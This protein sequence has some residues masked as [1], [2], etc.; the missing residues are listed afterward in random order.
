MYSTGLLKFSCVIM[1]F[2]EWSNGLKRMVLYFMTNVP[3][4]QKVDKFVKQWCS[5]KQRIS[6]LVWFLW[7]TF[8][9]GYPYQLSNTLYLF[10]SCV[11]VTIIIH[12]PCVFQNSYML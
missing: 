4:S 12:S 8:L 10:F 3:A 11:Y 1:D 5:S 9:Y 6:V 7:L 2:A